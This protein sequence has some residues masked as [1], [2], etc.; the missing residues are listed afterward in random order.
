MPRIWRKGNTTVNRWPHADDQAKCEHCSKVGAV[1]R[2]IFIAW[3]MA[4]TAA[5]CRKGCNTSQQV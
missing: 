3:G 4:V 1:G 5:Y 2:E